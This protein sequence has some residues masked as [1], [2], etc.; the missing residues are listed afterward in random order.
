MM[1]RILNAVRPLGHTSLVMHV[2]IGL[3]VAV[4]VAFIRSASYASGPGRGPLP[5]DA[6]QL[7][8]AGLGA[9]AYLA[10]AAYDYRR[11]VRWSRWL[12]AVGL[13]LLALVL[14]VGTVRYGA[15][16]WLWFFQ[17]SEVAKLTTLALLAAFLARPARNLAALGNIAL[18][19]LIVLVPAILVMKQPDLGTALVFVPMVL[20]M[21]YVAGVPGRYVGSLIAAGAVAVAVVGAAA[22]VP[23]ELDLDEEAQ[24][25]I[26]AMTGLSQY[27]RTRIRVFVD[28]EFDPLRAGWNLKQSII[29]VGS[30][31][32]WG[33]GYRQGDQNVLGFLPRKV[34]PTD[35]IYSVIA[36]EKGFMGTLGVLALY[37]AVVGVTLRAAAK[38]PDAAGRLLCVGVATM[39]F[40]H[41]FTNL[42]MTV[43]LM[44][45]TGLPLPLVSYGG[46]FM[47]VTLASLGLVQSVYA[48]SRPRPA[49]FFDR[50]FIAEA[51]V[52]R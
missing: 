8:W 40:F 11:F 48:R 32:V 39:M 50:P 36:E 41:V 51:G 18:A 20:A 44:P 14:V 1:R 15:R 12:Y 37:G 26:W 9:L 45:I 2:A 29:A 3:L 16:R 42:A 33:K 30:G 4:G 7:M 34:A 19:L 31:G 43:G 27:Q 22:I 49:H 28:P 21:M 24:D 13:A 52:L 46:S 6:R 25:R 10:C 17:P 5:L 47:L 38:A 35:F 23:Y